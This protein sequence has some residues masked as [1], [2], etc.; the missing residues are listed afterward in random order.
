M[1]FNKNEPHGTVYGHTEIAWEQNGKQFRP[2]GSVYEEKK[3]NDE[4]ETLTLN[5]K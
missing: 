4:R 3:Q 2:D 1:Q 5:R